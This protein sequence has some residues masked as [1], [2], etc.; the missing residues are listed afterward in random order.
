MIVRTL[1][2]VISMGGNL[3]IDI[4]PKADGSIP[5]E[6]VKILENLGRWTKKNS[7]AIYTTCQGL[8]LLITEGNLLY[9]L[10]VKSYFCIWKKLKTLQRF[11]D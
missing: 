8:P 1:A 7:D 11:M 3:L 10:M 5:A 6:Q 2:D 9:L 4:G